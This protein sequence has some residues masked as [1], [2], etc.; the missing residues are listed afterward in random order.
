MAGIGGRRKP[1]LWGKKF[2]WKAF[3]YTHIHDIIQEQK[4]RHIQRRGPAVRKAFSGVRYTPCEDVASNMA[5]IV[6]VITSACKDPVAAVKLID[7][8]YTEEGSSLLTWG[9][10]GESWEWQDGKKVLTD[11]ALSVDEEQGWLNLF[12]TGEESLDNFDRFVAQLDK[13]GVN[14]ALE[15]YRKAYESHMAK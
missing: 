13:M 5:T 8:M 15:I 4:C 10:E 3:V 1:A 9:I 7:Y 6:T 12:I 11:L 2:L 14:K